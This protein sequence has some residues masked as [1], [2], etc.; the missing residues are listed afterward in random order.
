MGSWYVK[1]IFVCFLALM[2]VLTGCT[3]APAPE[4]PAE[5]ESKFQQE[6]SAPAQESS[7]AE[8]SQPA[9]TAE[10]SASAESS[11]PAQAEAAWD[12]M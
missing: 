3:S 1:K 10:S 2:L 4:K 7:K 5:T 12:G 9:E 11:Q 6:A 8:A